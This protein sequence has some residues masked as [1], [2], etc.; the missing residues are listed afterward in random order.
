MLS[1]LDAIRALD[2]PLDAGAHIHPNRLRLMAREGAQITPQHFRDLE[3][4]RRYALLMASLLDRAE[5]LTDEILDLHDRI[6]LNMNRQSRH[7]QET[8][9]LASQDT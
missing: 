7:R 5:S 1:R 8:Q 6:L 3:A 4:E 9:V 2:L